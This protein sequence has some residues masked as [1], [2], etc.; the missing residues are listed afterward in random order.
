MNRA[1]WLTAAV[2]ALGTAACNP[3]AEEA[4][5]SANDSAEALENAAGGNEAAEANA[6]AAGNAAAGNGSAASFCFYRPDDVKDWKAVRGKAGTRSAGMVI[7]TGKA[8]TNDPQYMAQLDKT[9]VE[10]G[11]LRLW[12][13]KA[14]QENPE[15]VPE[16]GW[17]DLRYGPGESG[18]TKVVVWCDRETYLAELDV[19]ESK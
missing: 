14:K 10:G 1:A 3:G 13:T 16:D 9:G 2:L 4:N 7:V 17:Y 5:V 15:E 8:R 19:E 18:V 11:V 12:L 6:A